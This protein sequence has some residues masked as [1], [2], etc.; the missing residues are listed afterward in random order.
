MFGNDDNNPYAIAWDAASSRLVVGG[1]FR[2]VAGVLATNVAAFGA[3]GWTGF[4]PGT[5]DDVL[6][7]IRDPT[8]GDLY[9]GG[10]FTSI[11]GVPANRV[12]RWDG[13]RWIALGAGIGESAGDRV[14]A[15]AWDSAG[16]R[17]FA[18]GNFAIAGGSGA[19]N[20][21]V[22]DGTR[23]SPLGAGLRADNSMEV[24][25]LAWDA[26]RSRLVATGRFDDAGSEGVRNVA[27]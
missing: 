6:E 3:V 25:D 24:N 26:A 5:N 9:A 21:A 17:L 27:I 8:T 18:G 2:E 15:L 23:W 7:I 12:A 1:Q 10:E 11:D 20:I 22:W 13:S 14:T 19:S 16:R 4:A